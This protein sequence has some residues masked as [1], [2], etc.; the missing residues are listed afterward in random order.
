MESQITIIL[1]SI[2]F[3][4]F[5]SGME[6]AYVSTNKIFVEIEKKQKGINSYFIKKI[7][8]NPSKF[9]AT[10]LLGNTLSLVVYGI[11]TGRLII[12]LFFPNLLGLENL[13][14]EY[15]FYQTLIS[16]FLIL[17]TSEFLPKVLFQIYANKLFKFFS[18]PTYFFYILLTPI[19]SFLNWISNSILSKYFKTK[20]D[21]MKMFFSKDELGDYIDQEIGDNNDHSIDT[22]IKIFKNALKFSNVRAREIMIQRNDIVSVDRYIKP[23]VLKEIF[24]RTGL[25]KILIHKENIDN[26]IGYI[27]IQRFFN[28]H[29]NFKSIIMPIEFVPESMFINDLLNLLTKKKKGIAV[30]VD[31]YGGCAGL[32][33]IE[34]IVEELIGEIEDEHDPQN[35][36]KKIVLSNQ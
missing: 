19:T 33:T 29:K 34:D 18:F 28:N 7:T 26:I 36:D 14:L 35:F 6:I 32:I 8:N 25:S 21:E 20:K 11:F 15:I 27:S 16:T 2:L 31:E 5:F 9:I 23:N 22:E 17:I 1:I 3:S 24:I 10:M 12:E 13:N 4:S 30:V